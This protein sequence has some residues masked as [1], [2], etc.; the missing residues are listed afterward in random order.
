[1]AKKITASV[2]EPLLTQALTNRTIERMNNGETFESIEIITNDDFIDYVCSLGSLDP[3]SL[4]ADR[5][6]GINRQVIY[7]ERTLRRK[8]VCR[9]CGRGRYGLAN[10]PTGVEVKQVEPQ[11]EPQSPKW[12]DLVE[13]EKETET[14]VVAKSETISGLLYEEPTNGFAD[15]GIFA[16]THFRNI[17]IS[18]SKC[19][20]RWSGDKRS[21]CSRCP[22]AKFC[23]QKQN[24]DLEAFAL[25]YAEQQSQPQSAP[26]NQGAKP[27]SAPK[28]S[29]KSAKLVLTS[30]QQQRC[31]KVTAQIEADCAHCGKAI[32]T[33][34]ETIWVPGG[35][36]YHLDCVEGV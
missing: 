28:S 11:S 16:D 14:L 27:N 2:I 1:M 13:T 34:S 26:S 30:E 25:R 20:G 15:E 18:Q 33:G 10:P 22:L 32:K 12:E 19:F 6:N 17:A 4:G 29:K 35:G 36:T 7:A 8:G 23:F 5:K 3:L 24:L 31:R 9:K 21:A